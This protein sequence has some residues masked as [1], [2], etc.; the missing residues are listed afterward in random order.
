M[1]LEDVEDVEQLGDGLE[2][3]GEGR[4]AELDLVD[5]GD[6]VPVEQV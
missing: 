3:G 6:P 4:E 5:P 2:G 1:N